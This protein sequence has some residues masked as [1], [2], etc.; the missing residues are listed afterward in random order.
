MIVLLKVASERCV[1]GD[2]VVVIFVCPQFNE[3]TK[4]KENHH[5]Y[6]ERLVVQQGERNG[7]IFA[8][9]VCRYYCRLLVVSVTACGV[10]ETVVGYV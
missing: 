2:G 4:R 10:K 9:F 7:Q 1:N 8:T 3:E 5:Y 6:S